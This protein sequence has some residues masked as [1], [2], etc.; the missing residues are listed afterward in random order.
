MPIQ[1]SGRITSQQQ[2]AGVIQGE[3]GS[4]PAAQFAVASTMWNRMSTPGPYVGGGSGDV[5]SVVLPSQFNGYNST[6]NSNAMTLAG[7]LMSG[8]APPGGD[9]GNATF[10][11]APVAGNASWAAPGGAL[12]QPGTGGTNIGGNY[13]TDNLGAPS[14]NFR[15]PNYN[16]SGT[17][18]DG[19]T[20]NSSGLAA[21]SGGTG[22]DYVTANPNGTSS[23]G[24][25]TQYQVAGVNAPLDATVTADVAPDQM[26]GVT[27]ITATEG[28]AK[29]IGDT[30]TSIETAFG[31]G[32]A[33]VV[34]AAQAGLTTT[35][36]G[37]GDAIG[38]LF[39]G[40]ESWFIRG[41]LIVLGV[42]LVAIGLFV[43]MW[44]HGGKEATTTAVKMAAA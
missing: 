30:T 23:T 36:K 28:F 34:S 9:T 38:N 25:L 4:D 24:D 8:Q 17:L 31:K 32:T 42:I 27:K 44:D 13:F 14:S 18:A 29:L 7:A 3:A 26:A 11:A 19:S 10:F 43:L 1:W 22:G 2:L 37:A 40:L 33:S 39:S 20:D 35:L 41:G 5:G 16:G 12:F 21:G 6:P 15:A